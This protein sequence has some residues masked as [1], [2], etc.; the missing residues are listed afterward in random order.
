M[1][2]GPDCKLH[3]ETGKSWRESGATQPASP[4]LP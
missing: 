1:A 4:T 3:F 2:E